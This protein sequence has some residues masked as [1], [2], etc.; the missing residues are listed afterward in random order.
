MVE[1]W[2]SAI[3]FRNFPRQKRVLCV[4]PK[5]HILHFYFVGQTC[6]IIQYY[7]SPE[8]VLISTEWLLLLEHGAKCLRLELVVSQRSGVC[9]NSSANCALDQGTCISQ[10]I[11]L[12]QSSKMG[13][14]SWAE[15]A[16]QTH[17]E[18]GVVI[19]H[20][21]SNTGESSPITKENMKGA[22]GCE[23]NAPL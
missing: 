4:W 17:N 23:H 16:K 5:M 15:W 21:Y 2:S 19:H 14:G 20:N 8:T 9:V 6:S 10:C 1:H 7:T 11:L 3:F 18:L 12:S 22:L 13:T